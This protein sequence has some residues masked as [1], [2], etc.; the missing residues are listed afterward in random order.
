MSGFSSTPP[1]YRF[2]QPFISCL[3]LTFYRYT[4]VHIGVPATCHDELRLPDD[5]R[6][7]EINH[8]RETQDR[9]RAPLKQVPSCEP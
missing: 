3:D 9:K 7:R 6:N 2:P 4:L 1:Q 8:P 5:H